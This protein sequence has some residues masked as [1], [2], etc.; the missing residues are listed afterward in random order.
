MNQDYYI[1]NGELFHGGPGS[2]RKID[3]NSK[4]QRML[5]EGVD[6]ERARQRSIPAK[7]KSDDDL[8]KEVTRLENE[9]KYEKFTKEPS[10]LE[11]AKDLVNET[12]RMNSAVTNQIRNIKT[13]RPRMDLSEMSNKQM[14]DTIE[15]ERL[16][17]EYNQM[18]SSP[19]KQE[20]A[21]NVVAG[22]FGGIGT[23]LT[24]TGGALA[25]A[26]SIKELRKK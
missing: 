18:F 14:R 10:K 25:I 15:R 22:I 1:V 23:A 6:K 13:T 7:Y 20:K 9:R 21:K 4:R 24:I 26:C 19:S 8:K 12:E 3:P 5:R 16:E 17:R 2:G 11:S